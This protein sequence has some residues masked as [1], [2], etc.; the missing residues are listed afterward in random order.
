M[1][2]ERKN[3]AEIQK[4]VTDRMR[5]LGMN[6]D[7]RFVRVVGAQPSAATKGANW[8]IATDGRP[9][10]FVKALSRVVPNIQMLYD[11]TAD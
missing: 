10:D 11:L 7:P 2:R 6:H 5:G 8:R 1:A 9:D 4:I 3:A